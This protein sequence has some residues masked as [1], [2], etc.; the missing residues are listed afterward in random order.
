MPDALHLAAA[1][2]A[3]ACCGLGVVEAARL[4]N[5]AW[6]SGAWRTAVLRGARHAAVRDWLARELERAGWHETP[7]RVTALA[8]IAAAVSGG[9]GVSAAFLI[10]PAT[11][12]TLGLG[13]VLLAL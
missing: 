10:A 4:T 5:E 6:L 11:A 7:E 12:T 8:V 3:G 2:A 13:G 9:L 1:A